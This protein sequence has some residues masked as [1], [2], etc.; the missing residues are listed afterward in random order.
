M[1]DELSPLPLPD[2]TLRFRLHTLLGVTA[3]VEAPRDGNE[4]PP[5]CAGG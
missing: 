5:A 1:S 4:K 3:V 2:P